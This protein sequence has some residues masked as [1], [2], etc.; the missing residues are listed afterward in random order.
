MTTSHQFIGDKIPIRAID[1]LQQGNKS[2]TYQSYL[3]RKK[4]LVR[5]LILS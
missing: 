2:N 1:H 5:S 4:D 3:K